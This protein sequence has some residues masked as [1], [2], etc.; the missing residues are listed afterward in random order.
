MPKW[1]E[2][3][4]ECRNLHNKEKNEIGG[5]CSAYGGEKRCV[6]RCGEGLEGK[7]PLGRPRRRWEDKMY[8]EVGCGVWT[9]SSW[10]RMGT[11]GGHL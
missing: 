9:G 8:Q 3:T 5:A 1:D 10:L 7:R 11:C 2:V 6:Q 4:Q